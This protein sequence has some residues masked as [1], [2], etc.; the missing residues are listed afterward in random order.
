MLCQASKS[1]DDDHEDN[2]DLFIFIY[3]SQPYI[4]SKQPISGDIYGSLAGQKHAK[5]NRQY[6]RVCGIDYI[7]QDR[8]QSHATQIVYMDEFKSRPYAT[9]FRTCNLEY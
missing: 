2:N 7:P 8:G 1:D 4:S 3:G 6:G 9:I 5:T